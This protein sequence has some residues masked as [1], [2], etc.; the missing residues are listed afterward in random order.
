MSSMLKVN[1]RATINEES[2]GLGMYV[3]TQ[4]IV[5][6]HFA[7]QKSARIMITRAVV[8]L[9]HSSDVVAHTI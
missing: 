9:A 4:P 5:S 3:I 8:P 6:Y 1:K 2:N 7:K